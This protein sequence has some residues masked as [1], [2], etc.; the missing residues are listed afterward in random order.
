MQVTG[1]IT[2][3]GNITA[4]FSDDRLKTRLNNISDPLVKIKSL[5]GFEFELNQTSRKLGIDDDG[6]QVGVSAQ[7]VQKVLPQIVKPAPINENY[8][9]VQYERLVPLLI[10][11]IKELTER[12]ERLEEENKNLKG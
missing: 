9:T 8:L 10:E 3:T 5:N 4:Y 6:I 12:I 2:A 11:G 7:E 1:A